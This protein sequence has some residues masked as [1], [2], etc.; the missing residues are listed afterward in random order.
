MFTISSLTGDA[1]DLRARKVGEVLGSTMGFVASAMDTPLSK[2]YNSLKMCFKIILLHWVR[3][4]KPTVSNQGCLR[5][6]A[7]TY[8]AHFLV[9]LIVYFYLPYP[10]KFEEKKT[11]EIG[12]WIIYKTI[13]CMGRGW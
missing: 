9:K 10:I 8:V 13:I 4:T 11:T 5:L 12:D 3:A 1:T 7:N 6:Q 2:F